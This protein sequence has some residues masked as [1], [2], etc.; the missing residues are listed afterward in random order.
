MIRKKSP[1]PRSAEV[2]WTGVGRRIRE[3][4]GFDATQA[5]FGARIKVSQNYVSMM[6]RGEVEIGAVILLRIA[7]EFAKSLE[8]LLTGKD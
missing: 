4:R 6:E 8:W 3:L 2:D 1:P 7:R 5:D